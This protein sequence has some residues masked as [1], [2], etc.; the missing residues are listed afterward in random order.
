MPV[1]SVKAWTAQQHQKERPTYF[2][3]RQRQRWGIKAVVP[4]RFFTLKDSDL[5]QW[6]LKP[7]PAYR[8]SLFFFFFFFVWLSPWPFRCALMWCDVTSSQSDA[9]G[10]LLGRYDDKRRS[11]PWPPHQNL[12]VVGVGPPHGV[13]RDRLHAGQHPRL[14]LM[15]PAH[16]PGPGAQRQGRIH[17][18]VDPHPPLDGVEQDLFPG[19]GVERHK[20]CGEA[21]VPFDVCQ[22]GC[23]GFTDRHSPGDAGVKIVVHADD[24]AG[25]LGRGAHY[26]DSLGGVSV[27]GVA[28]AIWVADGSHQTFSKLRQLPARPERRHTA[29]DWI[30]WR[31]LGNCVPLNHLNPQDP[32]MDH[33]GKN[34]VDSSTA[35]RD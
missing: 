30:Q 22:Q 18:D 27:P 10:A 3:D 20:P 8:A 23:V 25:W 13:G 11:S 21:L 12:G 24:K 16:Q 33:W 6:Q 15:H 31:I 14:V 17:G 26:G 35:W 1:W 29:W 19:R 28:H 32:W 34:M 2:L 5:C 7:R 9:L 4:S